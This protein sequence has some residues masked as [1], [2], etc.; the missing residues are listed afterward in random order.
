[1]VRYPVRKPQPRTQ[2][3]RGIANRNRGTGSIAF[4]SSPHLQVPSGEDSSSPNCTGSI[5]ESAYLECDTVLCNSV[6]IFLPS[7]GT[8]KDTGDLIRSSLPVLWLSKVAASSSQPRFE[9]NFVPEISVGRSLV[10]DFPR[11]GRV[12]PRD[13]PL[14]R[15]VRG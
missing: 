14:A 6:C 15:P 5:Q 10:A 4:R 9:S 7:Q 12:F 1:M 13:G 3:R 11:K 8:F 2:P